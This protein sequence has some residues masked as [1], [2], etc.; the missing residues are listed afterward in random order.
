MRGTGMNL[1]IVDDEREIGTFL[2]HLFSLKG[3]TVHK[4]VSA[5]EF[6]Q[7]DFAAHVFHAA[8]I[9]IKLPD[10][11]GL[12]LLQHLKKQQP[13]CQVLIMTGYSTIKTAV[14]AMKLGASDYIEKPFGDIE[15]LEK[16]VEDLL[17][18]SQSATPPYIHK[19]AKEAG[20]LIGKSPVMNQLV[21]TTW[22]VAQKS[23]N[24][25]IEGETGTG[26]EVLSRFIHLASPR[27]EEPFIG[28]NCGAISE[29]LLESE[30]FGHERGAF[31]GATQQRKGFFEIAG[32]GTLFLDEIA[33]ATSAIQVKLLRVLE[34][35]EFM[36]VG[37]S[38]TLQTNARLVAATNE[39]LQ[40]A[41]DN[42]TFREDL[43]YRLNVVTLELPALRERKEDLPMLI[44]HFIERIGQPS[45]TFTPA[46]LDKLSSY[47][48]PGNIRELSNVVTRTLTFADQHSD[49]SADDIVLSS[50]PT[51]AI[52]SKAEKTSLNTTNHLKQWRNEKLADFNESNKINLE[53]VLTE[54]KQLETDI[55]KE[56]VQQALQK[57][58]GNRNEA[59]KR[60][61]ISMRKLRY[62]LNE[63]SKTDVKKP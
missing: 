6:Y 63:K 14:E 43:F 16:Q 25:L 52:S 21:E 54:I 3:F 5:N 57:T 46:A 58:F 24:V 12:A 62:L 50:C 8:M 60:L 45:I 53:N 34:T 35:R 20:M 47:D 10:G 28:I 40:Q 41:V 4:A 7:I 13:H 23:V 33:E 19:L 2:S 17:K 51:P 1:L 39:N 26:K 27:R 30:L 31:T 56:M 55:G 38:Q 29:S 61:H 15:I 11:S 32:S 44:H 49:I 42:R 36:R 48:W 37:S 9:D 18:R 59:A 22:K